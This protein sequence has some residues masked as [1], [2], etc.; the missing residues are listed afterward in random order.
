LWS[1][2]KFRYPAGMRI[3]ELPLE[4]IDLK[5][6]LF[7]ISHELESAPLLDSI[8]ESGQLNPLVIQEDGSHKTI[9]CG[10]RRIRAMRR[11]GMTRALTRISRGGECSPGRLFDLALRDNLSHRQL[12]PLEKAGVLFKLRQSFG[13]TDEIIVSVYL[14]I[15]GLN[16]HESVLRSHLLVHEIGPALRN[17]LKE[18]RLTQSSIETIAEMPPDAQ[19]RIASV[20]GTIRLS[21][22]LQKKV[23]ELLDDLAGSTGTAPGAVLE[24]PEVL[25][26]LSDAGLSSF[27]KGEKVHQFLN[28][29][30]NPRLSAALDRFLS[31]RESLQLPG[32]IRITAH[33]FFEEPGLRVEFGAPD[34]GHFRALASALQEATLREEF[35]DLFAAGCADGC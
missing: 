27:Q 5:N 11:L 25:S 24:Q 30:R 1:R 7:R 18:G 13:I 28:R 19:D 6:E 2:P 34:V 15:L 3:I 33:P 20:M 8:R 29:L 31:R 21:A 9:V 4:E 35:E 23:L 12:D 10:F 16:P 26:I 32:S 17:C 14:P 22:S